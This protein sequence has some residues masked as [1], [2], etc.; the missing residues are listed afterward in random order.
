VGV[1]DL[2]H[3]ASHIDEGSPLNVGTVESEGHDSLEE[4]LEGSAVP[5]GRQSVRSQ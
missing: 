2:G 3:I 1:E 4:E 5:V